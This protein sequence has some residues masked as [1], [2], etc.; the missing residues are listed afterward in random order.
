MNEKSVNWLFSRKP[1]TINWEP[2][3]NSI[4]VVSA[5]VEK[6]TTTGAQKLRDLGDVSAIEEDA[7]R[8]AHEVLK[9]V[10]A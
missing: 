5:T 2:K 9:K 3:A 8:I 10:V 7:R 6:L 4:E 1:R